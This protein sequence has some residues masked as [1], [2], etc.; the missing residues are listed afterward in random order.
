MGSDTEG[1]SVD[2]VS[3]LIEIKVLNRI[4]AVKPIVECS[5]FPPEALMSL[6]P[7]AQGNSYTGHPLHKQS[8]FNHGSPCICVLS[9]DLVNIIDFCLVFFFMQ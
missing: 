8:I 2:I 1:R 4:I 6:E 5:L 3:R 9:C 7:D